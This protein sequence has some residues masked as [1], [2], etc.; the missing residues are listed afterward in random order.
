[1]RGFFSGMPVREWFNP[2][3]PSIR[4]GRI[5][6]ETMSEAQALA[7]MLAEPLLIRRPLIEVDEHRFAGFDPDTLAQS[8]GGDWPSAARVKECMRH[9]D[10]PCPLP[11][12]GN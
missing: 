8:L 2:A 5:R 10:S 11:S 3:A 1:M 12:K 4:E 6:P 9:D 7:S